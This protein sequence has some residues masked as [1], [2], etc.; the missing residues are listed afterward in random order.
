[1]EEISVRKVAHVILLAREMDRGEAEMRGVIERMTEEEQAALVAV[2]WIG[3]DAFD[4]DEWNE[5]Y[6]TAL[7]EASTPTADYLIGTPHV[8]DH[9]EAGLEALGYD[10]SD[11]EDELLRRGA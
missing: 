1:M 6:A 8:A 4:A 2:M 3:R 9:L 5:A 7:S 11:E 10:S